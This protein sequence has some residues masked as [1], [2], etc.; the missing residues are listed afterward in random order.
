[1]SEPS[2]RSG[3][4]CHEWLFILLFVGANAVVAPLV[5]DL[6]PLTSMPM[7]SDRTR[8]ITEISVLGPDGQALSD[9]AAKAG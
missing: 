1:M 6:Y 8:A 2:K 3:R 4:Q 7:F 9:P 5:V